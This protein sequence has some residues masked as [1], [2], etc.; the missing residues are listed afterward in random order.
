MEHCIRL[1]IYLAAVVQTLV[2]LIQQ[3][4]HYPIRYV[5]GKPLLHY[6]V[7]RIYLSTFRT[8]QACRFPNK[9]LRD[10]SISSKAVRSDNS[11]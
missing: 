4:N 9:A 8:T 2:S 7:Y 6:P 10:K 1:A 5:L 11:D 3:R